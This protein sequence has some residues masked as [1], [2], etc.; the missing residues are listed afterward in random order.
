VAAI[1]VAYW[2]LAPAFPSFFPG[3]GQSFGPATYDAIAR[4]VGIL[5]VLIMAVCPI[6]SWRSTDKA[7]FWRRAKWPLVGTAGLG[8]VLLV[9]WWT[10][11]WPIYERVNPGASPLASPVH[12]WEAVIG[13]IVAAL[14]I[15][16][17][18]YVFVDGA[19][20]RA[21]AKKEG[22]F[23]ALWRIMS[24]ARTQSGGYLT[25]LGVGV[26]LIG[27]IGSSMFVDDYQFDLPD[28][29]G[30]S[31]EAAD[32]IFTYQGISEEVKSNGD[33][34]TIAVFSASRD[35]K[36]V[37]SLEPSILYHASQGQTTRN[38]D[39]VFEPL[40]DIFFIFEGTNQDGS[41]SIEVKVNPLISWAWV[42][43]VLLIIGTTLAVWP[44]KR[45]VA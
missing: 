11:L 23:T 5:Y 44:K 30:Q 3:G 32:Y 13:L 1:L 41:L 2:T 14:A 19:R 16:V 10:R 39:I 38:V 20:K 7:I 24:K 36:V 22:F 6:L 26:I 42:G 4:P 15:S 37:D 25:H 40:R 9:L 43:F 12:G 8:G 28:E 18:V 29:P 35:G 31:I 45:R 27:L 33:V 21:A 34:D 17:P